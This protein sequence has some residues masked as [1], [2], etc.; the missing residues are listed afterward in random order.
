MEPV[1]PHELFSTI[2]YT[3][4]GTD[5]P[6]SIGF[7]PDLVWTKP[8]RV[9]EARMTITHLANAKAVDKLNHAIQCMLQVLSP[10]QKKAFVSLYMEKKDES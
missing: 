6:P 1:K 10:K 2:T 8:R 5:V 4:T 3:G 9:D 7:N